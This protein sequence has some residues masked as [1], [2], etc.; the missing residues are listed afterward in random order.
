MD[1]SKSPSGSTRKSLSG[2]FKTWVLVIGNRRQAYLPWGSRKGFK[3]SQ[4]SIA[5]FLAGEKR[6]VSFLLG[7]DIFAGQ[8]AKW[9]LLIE[10]RGFPWGLSGKESACQCR[11]HGRCGFN[12]WVEKIPWRRKWQPTL[13]FLSGQSHGQRSLV[14]YSPWNCKSIGHNLVT[15]QQQQNTEGKKYTYLDIYRHWIFASYYK[16]IPP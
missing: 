13:V 4:N 6:D 3:C 5:Y 10:N 2:S 7:K 12:P 16:L 1:S 9:P 14:G 11:R 15:K 8:W